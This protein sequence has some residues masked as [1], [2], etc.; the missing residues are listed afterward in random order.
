MAYLNCPFCPAQ[1]YPQSTLAARWDNG[2]VLFSCESQHEFY[3][4]REEIYGRT[5]GSDIERDE[6]HVSRCC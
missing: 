5:T 2:L 3:V 4:E 1:A 6:Q